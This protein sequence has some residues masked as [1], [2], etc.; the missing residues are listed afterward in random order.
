MVIGDHLKITTQ[1]L[2]QVPL[3]GFSNYIQF[4]N[5][6]QYT[7]YADSLTLYFSWIVWKSAAPNEEAL[8]TRDFFLNDD[9]V[10][11]SGEYS[12]VKIS[13]NLRNI[14]IHNVLHYHV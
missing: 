6:F 11:D 9:P 8:D 4:S 2:F 12:T 3:P 1:K 14:T 7:Y 5:I 10:S 13:M